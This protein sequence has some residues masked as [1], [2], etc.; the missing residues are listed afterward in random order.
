MVQIQFAE[1]FGCSW[2]RSQ[3]GK[4]IRI[5]DPR[6]V[7]DQGW[8]FVMSEREETVLLEDLVASDVK[9][10]V[11]GRKCPEC[12]Q[13][14]DKQEAERDAYNKQNEIK[15]PPPPTRDDYSWK[16]IW[17]LPEV[18]IV[19]LRRTG[20]NADG[21]CK[22]NTR[23]DI[24]E[25]LDLTPHVD[26]TLA[27]KKSAKYRLRAF[28]CH[29]GEP[30]AGHY[31][32]WASINNVWHRFNDKKV[33]KSTLAQ[34]RKEQDYKD[35]FTPYLLLFER[36]AD[37]A[38]DEPRAPSP[39]KQSSSKIET[40]QQTQAATGEREVTPLEGL[41]IQPLGFSTYT[42]L[43]EASATNP[44]GDEDGDKGGDNDEDPRPQ[45]GEGPPPGKAFISIVV[46][47]NGETINFPKY[48]VDDIPGISE[49]Q[50]LSVTA[51]VE[52]N[53]LQ[54]ATVSGSSSFPRQW[55]DLQS[56]TGGKDATASKASPK[57]AMSLKRGTPEEPPHEPQGKRPRLT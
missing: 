56:K 18:L 31:I 4:N 6:L 13:K 27:G 46:E 7:E 28:V 39:E 55:G 47:F 8:G 30:G 54:K 25:E 29:R 50:T 3:P 53:D 44:S 9:T 37:A 11:P 42:N 16:R 15:R 24:P 22:I 52:N 12:G 20:Y 57:N 23:I 48:S 26:K 17:S 41:P 19:Q 5:R 34:A 36:V 14:A 21:P 43:P 1:R 2:C 35:P 32:A 40:A 33:N 38:E 49:N 45:D 51:T 10:V